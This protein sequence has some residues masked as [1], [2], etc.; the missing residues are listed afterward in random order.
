[1][2]TA[3]QVTVIT[4]VRNGAR[5]LAATIE[6]IR[7]Q[8]F[9][10]W[11]YIIVDD[12]STDETLQ[13]VHRYQRRDSRIKIF[14]RPVPAGP[15]T[16][17]ND[18]LRIA[19][20]RYV[21]R[22]DA[23]DLSTPDRIEKQL[24]FLQAHK[25]YRACVSYWQGLNDKGVIPRTV[26]PVPNNPRVFRWALL[27]RSASI[28]SAVCYER[29]MMEELGGYRE[30]PLS[31]DY[32]LWCE[33][34]RRNWLGTMPE[35]LCYVRAHARRESHSNFD[36]QRSLA[37]EVLS[38]HL[39]A[40]SGQR[41][42]REDLEALRS[43]GHSERMAAGKGIEMLDRWDLLW[44]AATDLTDEDRA[45]L[46][47]MSI[48]RRWKHLRSN[49]RTEPVP[50]LFGLVKLLATRPQFLVPALKGVGS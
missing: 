22:T 47:R 40:L 38:D 1:M 30:L 27:L 2:K 33:L 7:A 18:G 21:V 50:V 36:V 4:A 45:D 32:R 3:P 6:S 16:A 44:Q 15:Y 34:T 11:E 29:S 20:G 8:S 24:A 31:Q 10:D 25:E 17:A 19:R 39:F 12:A 49:A 35:V 14:T 13:I 42:S 43:V 28:H 41:W 9:T 26:T 37:L 5:Y 46:H 23:D 48:F